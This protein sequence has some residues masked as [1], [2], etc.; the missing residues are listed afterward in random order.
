MRQQGI[1]RIAYDDDGQARLW[2]VIWGDDDFHCRSW[3]L[4]AENV[5]RMR[6]WC[7]QNEARA[8]GANEL[9]LPAFMGPP[10]ARGT[11]RGIAA[12]WLFF[13]TEHDPAL[14]W[15]AVNLFHEIDPV[16]YPDYRRSDSVGA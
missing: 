7:E 1:C 2:S 14:C 3:R 10:D 15:A 12:A 5:N 13:A 4:D 6:A 8:P 16:K 9:P 11:Y